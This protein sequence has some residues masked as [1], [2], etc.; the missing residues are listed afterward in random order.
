LYSYFEKI[1]LVQVSTRDQDYI[2]DPLAIDITSLEAIFANP[3]IEK[4]FHAAEYD[5]MSLRRDYGFQFCNLFDS[6]LAA[7]IL[8]WPK[9]GLGDILA[10]HFKVAV[11]KQFQQYNWGMRPLSQEALAYARLDTHYLL[12]LRDLQHEAL[13]EA[14]RLEE[15]AEAFE[16]MTYARSALKIFDPADFWRIKGARK[17]GA[18]QQACLQALYIFRDRT[19]RQANRPPFKIMNASTLVQLAR[20]QPKTLK[21]LKATKGVGPSFVKRYGHQVIKLLNQP[22]EAPTP[23]QKSGPPRPP[24]AVLRRY[25]H[26]R[27]WRNEAAQARGVEPDVIFSN[28]TLLEIAWANPQTTDELSGQNLMGAWKFQRYAQTILEQLKECA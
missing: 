27:S 18:D 19:A 21:Q 17:L 7:R 12:A 2:V 25:E 5:I 3:A 6:M 4:I 22:H 9:Y 14:G 23:E 24:D 13:R 28:D 15:A 16:A 10:E 26:L 20:Q 1:C 8:G 11:N